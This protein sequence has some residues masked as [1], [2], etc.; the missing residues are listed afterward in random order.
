M[1]SAKRGPS[2][3]AA[4][5]GPRR[6]RPPTI[7]LKATEVAADPVEH[8]DPARENRPTAAEPAAQP[9]PGTEPL[10]GP[11]PTPARAQAAWAD[12]AA[13]RAAM[14]RTAV[15]LNG[16]MRDR[17]SWPL[18]GAGLAGA[19][20]AL[21]AVVLVWGLGTAPVPVPAPARDEAAL[22][23]LAA[24]ETQVRE[25]G[26]RPMPVGLD[27]RVISDLAGR[28]GAAEQ[29]AAAQEQRLGRIEAAPPP[30]QP[31]IDPA[32]INR[33]AALE[34]AVRAFPDMSK[35]IDE[36][37]LA[38]REAR[39]RADA[40]VDATR[41]PP[42]QPAP[43]AIPRGELDALAGRIAALEHAAKVMED[44]LAQAA[45]GTGADRPVR[46]AFA[47]IALRGAVERGEPFGRELAAVKALAPDAAFAALEPFAA[48]GVPGA[49]TLARELAQLSNPMLAAVS[50]VPRDGSLIDRLQHNAEKLV[51]IRPINA[52]P[53]DD[54]AAILARAEAKAPRDLAGA[55]AEVKRLPEAA[56]APAQGWM[57]RAEQ[58]V[59][60]VT[61]ARG[62]AEAAVAVLAR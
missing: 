41:A 55:L 50:G 2:D 33:I 40:A 61:A 7:D 24:L 52:A 20:V 9:A 45:P 8:V 62:L 49:A 31:G 3:P 36:A 60:A 56:R 48:T 37:A 22:N 19:A 16:W 32:L 13:M 10:P 17:T 12:F 51:R 54:P 59:A 58:Q 27:Q 43:A 53:G 47:A 39:T 29:K 25:L 30:P 28:L 35:R 14:A 44:R 42:V 6:R 46:L 26:S 5:P 15:E 18:L 23:R 57:S 21:G 34:A 4:P 11:K 1:A 38:A